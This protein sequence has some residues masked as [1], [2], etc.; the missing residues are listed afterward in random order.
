MRDQIPGRA[1]GRV[2]RAGPDDAQGPTKVKLRRPDLGQPARGQVIGDGQF[3]DDSGRRAGQHGGA[4]RRGGG[5]RQRGGSL[6]VA[7]AEG[8]GQRRGQGVPGPRAAPYRRRAAAGSLESEP[9][10]TWPDLTRKEVPSTDGSTASLI[11]IPIVVTLAL[12][13]WLL[14]VA[15]AYAAAHPRWKHG[16]VSAGP[17]TNHQIHSA[18]PR[19][20]DLAHAG[21]DAIPGKSAK[22]AA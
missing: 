10:P 20:A 4:D 6:G 3:A 1:G 13:A 14:L 21:Q 15:Y 7:R 16:T 12:A 17:E 5:H 22:L 9:D 11:A 19:P 2:R 18:E 8:G